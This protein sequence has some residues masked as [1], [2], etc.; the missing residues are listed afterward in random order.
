MYNTRLNTH[1]HGRHVEAGYIRVLGALAIFG[2]P[3][4]IVARR[5]IIG[6]LAKYL[7]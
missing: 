6:E 2:D 7:V 1:V 5:E 3:T 4:A